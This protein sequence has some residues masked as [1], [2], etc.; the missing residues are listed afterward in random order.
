MSKNQKRLRCLTHWWLSS[1]NTGNGNNVYNVTATGTENN[2]NANN[3]YGLAP[4]L[5]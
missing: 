1:A 2:N 4:D 5:I 3:S